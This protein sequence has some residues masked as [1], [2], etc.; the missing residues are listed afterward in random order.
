M[1]HELVSLPLVFDRLKL[2][3][4]GHSVISS[5]RKS[6]VI[7]VVLVEGVPRPILDGHNFYFR[8]IGV[9]G[10]DGVK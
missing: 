5:C 10:D 8:R 4:R 6:E 3:I 1:T 7:D 2:A 9:I